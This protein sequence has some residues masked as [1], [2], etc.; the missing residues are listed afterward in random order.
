[1]EVELSIDHQR[2]GLG[3]DRRQLIN[4]HKVRLRSMEFPITMAAADNYVVDYFKTLE[5]T[6]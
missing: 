3:V 6:C 2:P 4:L 5:E 1:M